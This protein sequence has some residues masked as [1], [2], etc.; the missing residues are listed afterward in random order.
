MIANRKTVDPSDESSTEVIQVETAMGAALGVFEGARA[1]QVPRSRFTPVKT[2]NDLLGVRSDAYVLT[3]EGH[4]ELSPERHDMPPVIDLDSSFYKLVGDFEA[5]FPAGAP[6]LV[7]CDRLTVEGDVVFG[8][9]I[10]IRGT[11]AIQ[12]RGD[13]PLHMEDGTVLQG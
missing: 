4:V 8:R 13:E 5:H 3:D 12:H 1:V 11:V 7:A 10:V 6:S 9:D 2:T